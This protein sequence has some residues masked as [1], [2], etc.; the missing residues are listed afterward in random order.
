[1]GLKRGEWVVIIFSLIYII[2][3]G[4]YYIVT[5]NY[6]FLTYV[7]NL[8]FVGAIVLLTLKKTKLDNLA[9]WL[10]SIWGLLHMLGGSIIIQ[11]VALYNLKLIKIIELSGDFFI[12]KMDQVIHFYG[13]FVAAVVVF[14]IIAPRLKNRNKLGAAIFV[15]WLGSMGLGSLN[16]IVEFLVFI[17]VERTGVGD[18]YN[19]GLDLISNMLGALVGSFFAARWYK[20]KKPN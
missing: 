11:G 7:V 1:M 18:L 5:E 8:V 9:L 17:F 13:F 3:F 15:A 2:I 16:E 12:L 10:L 20:R 19:L 14:Q 6:E 4:I